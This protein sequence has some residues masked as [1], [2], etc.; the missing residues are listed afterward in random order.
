MNDDKVE[1]KKQEPAEILSEKEAVSKSDTW[2]TQKLFNC[3]REELYQ[4]GTFTVHIIHATANG[5][6]YEGVGFSKAHPNITISQYD[7]DK[8]KAV[9]RGRSIHDLFLEFGKEK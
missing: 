9:A 4:R 1:K 8:G 5:K 7:P 2:L 3:V 6:E